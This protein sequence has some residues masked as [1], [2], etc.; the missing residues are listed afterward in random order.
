MVHN[1]S[2]SLPTFTLNHPTNP[3]RTPCIVILAAG[4]FISTYHVNGKFSKRW[5]FQEINQFFGALRGMPKF[6]SVPNAYPNMAATGVPRHLLQQTSKFIHFFCTEDS[7][8]SNA[9][10]PS[11]RRQNRQNGSVYQESR[12]AN[13]KPTPMGCF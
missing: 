1:R 9:D 8:N 10:E 6:L 7:H 4:C 3:W 5:H 13:H 11:Y 2:P 12:A